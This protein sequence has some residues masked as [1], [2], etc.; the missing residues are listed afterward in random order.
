MEP[1]QT[2]AED[3]RKTQIRLA[4]RAYRLRKEQTLMALHTKCNRLE[5][6]ITEIASAFGQLSDELRRTQALRARPDLARQLQ[7]THAMI[8]IALR[9]VE[10]SRE[11]EMRD[12]AQIV[13]GGGGGGGGGGSA[14][15]RESRDSDFAKG[16]QQRD[17]KF[18][19]DVRSIDVWGYR[20][21]MD[22]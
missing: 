5:S 21:V 15:V 17:E 14:S 11:A 8:Q 16:L 19:E 2:E 4:Q 13:Y 1:R 3:K 12:D 18:A 10:Q 7:D 9:E 20:V 6:T 22:P